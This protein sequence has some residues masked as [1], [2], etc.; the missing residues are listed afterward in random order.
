MA[1]A[2]ISLL[3]IFLHTVAT[4]LGRRTLL[5][6]EAGYLPGLRPVDLAVF[7]LLWCYGEPV[8]TSRYRGRGAT[9]ETGRRFLVCNP[10]YR[11]GCQ[12]R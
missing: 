4:V 9:D 5:P 3:R 8:S 7:I 1:P 6:T 12:I 10:S 2:R 11:Q